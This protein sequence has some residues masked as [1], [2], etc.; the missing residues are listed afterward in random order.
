[1]NEDNKLSLD[2][3]EVLNNIDIKCIDNFNRLFRKF[4]LIN[5]ISYI[6]FMIILSFNTKLFF[7]TYTTYF[8]IIN[9][10]YGKMF[11][12]SIININNLIYDLIKIISY[13]ETNK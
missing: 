6:S 10:F 4:S 13:K 12:N 3:D 1:M 11:S 8:I 5:S 2:V 9:L 7:V